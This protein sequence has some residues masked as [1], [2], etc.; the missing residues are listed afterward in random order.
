M[1]T[2]E[3]KC[4]DRIDDSMKDREAQITAL[5]NDPDSDENNDPALSI[6]TR[7]VTI[8]CLSWGGPADYLEITHKGLDIIQVIYRFSDWF[9]SATR[10]VYDGSSLYTYAQFILESDASNYENN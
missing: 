2:K 1:T 8:V 4:A 9:D 7:K 6:D 5:L 10:E 3:K